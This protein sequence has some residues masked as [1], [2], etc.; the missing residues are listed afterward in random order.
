MTSLTTDK[1]KTLSMLAESK[2]LAYIPR[3]PLPASEF[4]K[5]EFMMS[6]QSVLLGRK[7]QSGEVEDEEDK[8]NGSLFAPNPMK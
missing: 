4:Q 7:R 1:G 8:L 3:K 2:K 6:N 5:R